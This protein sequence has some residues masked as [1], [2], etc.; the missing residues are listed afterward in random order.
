MTTDVVV[1]G[2][3]PAGAAAAITAARSGRSVTIV[4]RAGPDAPHL[5]ETWEGARADLLADLGVTGLAELFLHRH[6]VHVSAPDGTRW[7]T[8][9]VSAGG[10]GVPPTARLDRT[11][12]DAALADA[13]AA[14][15]V[16]H[17]RGHTVDIVDPGAG[18]DPASGTSGGEPILSGSR[19]DGSRWS[20]RGR[21]VVDASGKSA[22]LGRALG[23][24]RP[25]RQLDPRQ[26]V[27]SHWE[28][29][30]DRADTLAAAGTTSIVVLDGGY[31]F[32]I[33]L[34]GRRVSVGIVLGTDTASRAAAAR[35]AKAAGRS[36]EPGA[37]DSCGPAAVLAAVIA[38]TPVLA[39]LLA[40]ARQLLPAI[41]AMNETF[42]CVPAASR[43]YALAGDAAGFDDP[44]LQRGV[45]TA[46]ASGLRAGG[47]SILATD[48]SASAQAAVLAYQDWLTADRAAASTHAYDAAARDWRSSVAGLLA[49]PHLPSFVPLAGLMGLATTTGRGPAS[50][51]PATPDAGQLRELLAEARATYASW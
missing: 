51:G 3:G 5:P 8:V 20:L 48:P 39:R 18:G 21:F 12:F 4:D 36:G 38:D 29:E 27:F 47:L 16:V 22:T 19:A 9:E 23:L 15:G 1:I 44:F 31:A 17:L 49:D 34:G 32:V 26:A 14:A 42:T 41:P 11:R 45:D 2:A 40:G 33:P 7:A 43:W 35:H 28:I 10:Q 6:R 46:L 30:A 50:A 25:G 24:Y 37:A 13:A